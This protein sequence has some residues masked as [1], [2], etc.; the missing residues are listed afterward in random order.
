MEPG[1]AFSVDRGRTLGVVSSRPFSLDLCT[2]IK[3]T[4]ARE[5]DTFVN[6]VNGPAVFFH[7]ELDLCPEKKRA[8][9]PHV[10]ETG[11]RVVIDVQRLQLCGIQLSAFVLI[12]C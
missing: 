4:Q 12:R 1:V 5:N 9:G 6:H 11:P 7:C 2:I 8:F 3:F 10:E